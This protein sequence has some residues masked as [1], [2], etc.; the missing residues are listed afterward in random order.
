[1]I[2]SSMRVGG[3]VTF[4]SIGEWT[5]RSM[6][7]HG[8]TQLGLENFCPKPRTPAAALKDALEALHPGSKHL[9]QALEADDAYEVV[10]VTRGEE[11]NSYRQVCR[12][13]VNSDLQIAAWPWSKADELVEQFNQHLGLVRGAAVTQMLVEVLGS[14]GGTPLRPKGCVYWLPGS[15]EQDWMGVARVVEEAAT[16]KSAVY[17]IRH[18]MDLDAMRA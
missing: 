10:E 12:A 2:E 9:I 5:R 17:L 3:V 4:S 18:Q 6:L 13:A 8:L 16:S 14:L 11:Q 15:K 7:L 1:M